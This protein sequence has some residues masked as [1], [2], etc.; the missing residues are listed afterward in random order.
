MEKS[1]ITKKGAETVSNIWSKAT[2]LGKKT[3]DAA[4]K[5]VKA[6]SEKAQNDSYLRKMKKYN[7]LFPKQYKS[8]EFNIP[9]M[10]MIVDDAVRRDIDVCEGAIGWLAQESG[11][12]VLCLYD[13]YIEKSGINFVPTATCDAV[14]Y[15]DSYN[16]N[17]FIRVDCIFG[18]AHEEK[19]AELEHV[20]YCLGAKSCSIEIVEADSTMESESK[21]VSVDSG[22][23]FKKL[24][25]S[26]KESSE[27]SAQTKSVNQRSGKTTTYFEGNNAPTRPELKWFSHDDN[28]KG[29]IEMRCSNS[30]AIKSKTLVL[31]GSSSATMSQKTAC[32]I[33][34]A[35]GKIA[36]VKASGA[37]E[38]QATR[39]NHSKLI[40][41]VEF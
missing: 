23:G 16:R 38:K 24:S 25:V 8:K 28:I 11:M 37:M 39:E 22:G 4:Q 2:V 27:R 31:E 30:N 18:K 14:Y 20:A 7:P 33:D 29:L 17:R 35:M 6:I 34:N 15:V 3:A 32:A 41:E 12:E 40:F 21:S 1:E 10:I 19:V 5:G 13:E 36:S 9:N 26:S